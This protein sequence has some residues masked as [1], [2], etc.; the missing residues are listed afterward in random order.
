LLNIAIV[1]GSKFHRSYVTLATDFNAIETFET[2][3]G[4]QISLGPRLDVA[5]ATGRR[6]LAHLPWCAG[7]ALIRPRRLSLKGSFPEFASLGEVQT[8]V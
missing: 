7:L 1:F 4:K 8:Y 5:E 2:D 6:N 3:V